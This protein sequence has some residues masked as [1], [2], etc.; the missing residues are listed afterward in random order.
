M[1][2]KVLIFFCLI[3]INA[4]AR[5]LILQS[6]IAQP[7]CPSVDQSALNSNITFYSNFNG[8][9]SIANAATITPTIGSSGTVANPNGVGLS[10]STGFLDQGIKFGGDDYVNFGTHTAALTVYTVSLWVKPGSLSTQTFLFQRGDSA[11]CFYNPSI[12]LV[13]STGALNFSESGCGGTGLIASTTIDTTV[14]THVAV[15]RDSNIAKAY[16]NGVLIM[17]D[18]S[19]PGGGSPGRLTVGAAYASNTSTYTLFTDST[20]DELVIWSRALTDAEITSLYAM[21][22][23]N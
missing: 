14:W 15:T 6:L 20:V 1:L 5:P 2:K 16:I 21:Q 18:T 19:Q 17:T 12:S 4:N 11:G 13:P 3:S 7:R 10:Y 23:C 22:T 8:T 9:G